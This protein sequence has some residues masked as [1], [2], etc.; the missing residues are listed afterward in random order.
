MMHDWNPA[1]FRCS[2]CGERWSP[3]TAGLPCRP[4][5]GATFVASLSTDRTPD[6]YFGLTMAESYGGDAP[7][8]TEPT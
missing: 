8:D 6:P 5:D 7:S 3:P 2:A 4:D 1:T